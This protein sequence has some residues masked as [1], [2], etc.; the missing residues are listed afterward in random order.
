MMERLICLGWLRLRAD[1]S[2]YLYGRSKKGLDIRQYG[3]NAGS[4]NVLRV[5]GA[6]GMRSAKTAGSSGTGGHEHGLIQ[7]PADPRL[8][9]VKSSW[10]AICSRR[11]VA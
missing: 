3:G 7:R 8:G 2:G 10:A 4:T 11:I 5:M 9:L 1:Q 6:A